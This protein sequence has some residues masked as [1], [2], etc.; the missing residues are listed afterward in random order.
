MYRSNR[1]IAAV[2]RV[3]NEFRTAFTRGLIRAFSQQQP[4]PSEIRTRLLLLVGLAVIGVVLAGV[5]TALGADTVVQPEQSARLVVADENLTVAGANQSETVVTDLS[6]VTE[7]RIDRE[8]AGRF[9]VET[10]ER[11]PLSPAERERARTIA[12]NN[13]TVSEAV[14]GMAAVELA[15][16][17]IRKLNAS[18]SATTRY[19]VAVDAGD[20]DTVTGDTFTIELNDSGGGNGSVTIDRT[21]EFVD[22]RAVVEVRDPTG[23]PPESLEYTVR[24]D[25][26]NGTVTDITDWE[27]VRQN[28]TT[29]EFSTPNNTSS[30][31]R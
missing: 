25:T 21:P 12:L 20:G 23:E 22:D 7:I 31:D 16:E 2:K 10:R 27:H 15:V 6:N 3:L 5:G 17:P 29:V 9:T 26:A 1:E 30:T 19:N 14:D 18:S 13:Q 8:N 24:V 4:V 11:R 28:A